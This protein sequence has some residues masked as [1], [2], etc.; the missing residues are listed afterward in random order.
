MSHRKQQKEALRR[1]R[2]ERERQARE[3]QQRKRM[4]G[5]GAAGL[6]AIAAVI[7][8]VVVAAGGDGG[9]GADA[10]ASEMLPDGGSVSEQQEF[11][12]A[13]AADGAGCELRS[14]RARSR[15]H[16]GSLDQ[17][18]N[19]DTNPPTSGRHY[20]FPADDGAYG[21][22]PQDE[23]LVHTLEHGRVI[24]WFKPSLSENQRADLKSLFDED[25]YQ[26][27][28][29]P[30]ADMPYQVAASAWNRDPLPNGTGRLL[31]CDRM[32]PEVFDAL[33]AFRDE[34]RSN[35]PEPVP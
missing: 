16:T 30:R 15:Q 13:A 28:L 21:E 35:G 10:A 7:V 27:L 18:V 4:V 31:T 17:R 33:R 25:S 11:D 1:E 32:T 6:I 5:F 12:L 29:V 9:S 23:Q 20:Q 22:A 14:S 26:L 8:L 3:A 19:Y 24:I 2:E 34:H